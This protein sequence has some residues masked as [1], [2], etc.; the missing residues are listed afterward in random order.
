MANCGVNPGAIS[1]FVEYLIKHMIKDNEKYKEL[2][3]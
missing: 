1:I 2:Y 3:K